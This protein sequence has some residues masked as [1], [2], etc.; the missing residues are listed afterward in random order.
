ML[1]RVNSLLRLAFIS[2]LAG[3]TPGLVS[4]SAQASTTNSVINP[5]TDIISQQATVNLAGHSTSFTYHSAG[6]ANELS[7]PVVL[8]GGGPAFS[9]WNLTPIQEGLKAQH[10]VIRMDMLGTG[11]NLIN[12]TSAILPKWIAQIEALRVALKAPKVVLAG[13]SWGGLMAMLYARDY[14]NHVEKLIFLNP[15][16]PE[17][18]AMEVLASEINHRQMAQ[19]QNDFNDESNW[20]NN[21]SSSEHS[22]EYLTLRQIKQVLPTY[23]YD[24]Q[25]GVR[26]AEQFTANDFNLLLN[27][28]AW[29]EYEKQTVHYNQTKHWTFPMYFMDCKYDTLMPYNLN[30]M[31]A[32]LNFKQVD[33]LE[34]CSHFPWEEEPQPFYELMHHYLK[35]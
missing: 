26:Y 13:H 30:A 7:V 2:L 33:I 9:S 34:R 32:Q 24:Y 15:V 23:F 8:L 14:P 28:Q 29:Q 11:E 25:K 18:K 20:D 4:M 19:G 31:Q 5:V 35:S 27:V 12:D 10:Q 17:L 22:L 6:L 21:A 1:I 3:F 16:D